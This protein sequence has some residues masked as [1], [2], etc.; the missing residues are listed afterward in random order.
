MRRLNKISLSEK[1]KELI[2]RRIAR[3]MEEMPEIIFAFLHGSL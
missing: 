2:I 1:Q 3:Q